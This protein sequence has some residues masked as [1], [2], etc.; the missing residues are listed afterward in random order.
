MWGYLRNSSQQRSSSAA[1]PPWVSSSSVPRPACGED[2]KLRQN[3]R[4][5]ADRGD[6]KQRVEEAEIGGALD[7]EQKPATT[8]EVAFPEVKLGMRLLDRGP[9][10]LPA[11]SLPPEGHAQIQVS[12]YVLIA[13]FSQH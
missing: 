13:G 9:G 2:S 8:F 12:P 4:N 5:A 10:L 7:A 3:L 1:R 11:V 6:P